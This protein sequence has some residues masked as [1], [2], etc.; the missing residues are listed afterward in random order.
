M[1]GRLISWLMNDII[2]NA[3]ANNKRFQGLAVK[4]DAMVNKN[5]KVITEDYMKTGEKVAKEKVAK[6]KE[7]QYGVIAQEFIAEFKKEI[8]GEINKVKAPTPPKK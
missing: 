4:I 6:L 3:L 7:S 2:V 8:A 1:I 5:K